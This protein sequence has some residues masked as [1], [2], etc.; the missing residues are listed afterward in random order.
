MFAAL[1]VPL[2]LLFYFDFLSFF[3]YLRLYL[4]SEVVEF[5]EWNGNADIWLYSENEKPSLGAAWKLAESHSD[6]HFNT[7]FL[8]VSLLLPLYFSPLSFALTIPL[9]LSLLTSA[10]NPASVPGV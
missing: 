8:F 2:F 3:F 10:E 4:Y 6:V 1:Y 7:S 9:A 5:V